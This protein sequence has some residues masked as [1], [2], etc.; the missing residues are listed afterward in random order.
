MSSH[1]EAPEISKD[2]VADSTD[3]YAF[4]SP[5]EPDTVTIIANYVPLE[6]PDGG[7][8]LLRVR[9]R[10]ALRHQHRQ[11]QRRRGRHHLPVPVH[12]PGHQPRHLPLQHR[13]HHSR[14]PTPTGT[15]ARPTGDPGR[16][17]A[18]RAATHGARHRPGL[19]AV[20][21]RAAVDPELRRRWPAPPC[22]PGRAAS[23]CSPASGPRASTSTSGRSSTSASCGP[24]SRTTPPSGSTNTGLGTDGG[25][26]QLHQG[27]QRPQHRHPGAHERADADSGRGPRH[28]VVANSVIGVWTTAN[29]QKVRVRDDVGEHF[30]HRPVRARC[31]GSGNPLINEVLIPMGKKDYWN[32]QPPARRQ[33]VRVALRQ[34]AAGPAAARCCTPGCSPTWP[35]TTRAR[36]HPTGPTSWPSSSPASRP[37]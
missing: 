27:R 34:P 30:W 10:R 37:G 2:P 5:D 19:P 22:T 23:P 32:S 3:L 8:E 9:R 18:R 25:R 29:R 12:R 11:R 36:R 15:A 31:R 16:Q 24:S 4:V 26:R 6:G 33:P 14:S 28:V 21:H 7:P 35:P 20:Q 1:R 17:R 13:A